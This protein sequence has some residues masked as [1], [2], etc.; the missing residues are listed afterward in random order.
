MERNRANQENGKGQEEE[1][2]ISQLEAGSIGMKVGW[3]WVSN[4]ILNYK[5]TLRQ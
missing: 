4:C 3:K 5:L 2:G 1:P